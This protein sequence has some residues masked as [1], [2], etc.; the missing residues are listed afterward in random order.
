MYYHHLTT[1]A[2][3]PSLPQAYPNHPFLVIN[4]SFRLSSGHRESLSLVSTYLDATPVYGAT[5]KIAFQRKTG[6][7]GYLKWVSR[8]VTNS[9]FLSSSTFASIHFKQEQG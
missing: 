4:L 9:T 3:I 1:N 6:Y 2:S 8:M 7:F 5:D